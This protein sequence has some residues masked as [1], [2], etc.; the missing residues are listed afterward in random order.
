MRI[1]IIAL[2]CL[3]N[4]L[5]PPAL[6][7]FSPVQTN[8]TGVAS[9][10]VV[11]SS[12]YSVFNASSGTGSC[13][14]GT[15]A[16]TATCIV[17]LSSS[18][19]DSNSCVADPPINN[20]FATPCQTIAHGISLLRDQSPD[21]LLLKKGDTFL[22]QTFDQWTLRGMNETLV[23]TNP[24]TYTGLMVIGAWPTTAGAR[25]IV[26]V[27]ASTQNHCILMQGGGGSHTND[28]TYTAMQSINCYNYKRDPNNGSFTANIDNTLGFEIISAGAP[29]QQF[30]L[31]EDCVFSF[32]TVGLNIQ[33]ST[34]TSNIPTF[35]FNGNVVQY[36]YRG[37][38]NDRHA[39]GLLYVDV[40]TPVIT[41]NVF[42]HNGWYNNTGTGQP[43]DEFNHN[44][45]ENNDDSQTGKA[46]VTNN[47]ILSAAAN[48]MEAR[49]GASATNNYFAGNAIVG[50]VDFVPSTFDHNVFTNGENHNFPADNG[51]AW[52][53]TVNNDAGNSNPSTLSFNIVANATNTD[54][55][56]FGLQL[57][58]GTSGDTATGNIVCNWPQPLIDSGSGNTTTGNTLQ[59]AN[60]T[61]IGPDP[62]HAT[63]ENFDS[64]VLGG[65]GTLADYATQV[66]TQSKDF[67]NPN[68]TAGVVN[69]YFRTKLGMANYP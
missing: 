22:N 5:V 21:W 35:V 49:S 27:N 29:P 18:G 32:F 62:S 39:E 33:G 7:L 63:I 14:L 45:Y 43:A 58:T 59:A 28:F 12:I 15:K 55:G 57:N 65:P 9:G 54:G 20:S 61:G 47:I 51:I 13:S 41:N 24:N 53:P 50:Y 44:I 4:I 64:S 6:A 52:G 37:S 3:L 34:G 25:P 1:L 16:S 8:G 11:N 10:V 40:T 26:E 48:G 31:I 66:S 46:T 38:T 2:L 42:N 67:Y 56:S 17:Y 19:S 68:F 36:N 23:S 30:F 69:N 60:C